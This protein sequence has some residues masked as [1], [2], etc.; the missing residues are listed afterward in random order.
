[1]SVLYWLESIRNPFLDALMQFFTFF[2]EELLFIVL[3]LT[4]FWCV[5]K[6]E[7]YYLLFVGFFGTILNQ[8]LKLLYRIP[9]PWVRDPD[10][11]PVD[12][13]VSGATGCHADTD[14][15]TG[16]NTDRDT[17]THTG[18]G[19]LRFRHHFG[20]AEASDKF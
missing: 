12:S 16:T 19:Q 14:L 6:R 3:A 4:V 9:R 11:R 8:F 10:F 7:G 15:D 2:G 20:Y 13:A 17:Y 18:S 5:D 1:M